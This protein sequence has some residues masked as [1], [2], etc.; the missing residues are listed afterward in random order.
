LNSFLA[1]K[2]KELNNNPRYI[3]QQ[4]NKL[5]QQVNK[6]TA[7][8]QSNISQEMEDVINNYYVK[9]A[10]T[11]SEKYKYANATI[12]KVI[13]KHSEEFKYVFMNEQEYF[14]KLI[15]W[16]NRKENEPFSELEMTTLLML[17]TSL[18]IYFPLVLLKEVSSGVFD[19][20][21]FYDDCGVPED[22]RKSKKTS[23]KIK[24]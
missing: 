7:V 13:V 8:F 5:Q 19:E 23:K 9:P 2:L 6:M 15:E 16:F 10:V 11:H 17:N 24:A 3:N 20:K 1:Q 22:A 14:I 21:Q 12:T 18:I 4:L